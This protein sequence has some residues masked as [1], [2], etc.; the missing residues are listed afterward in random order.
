MDY[1]DYTSAL[2]GAW[3]EHPPRWA[4]SGWTY[5]TLLAFTPGERNVIHEYG[6]ELQRRALVMV[7]ASPK[8]EE[9]SRR[10]SHTSR[11]PGR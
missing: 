5:Q 2:V 11:G 10:Q 3:P 6:V 1:A 8:P 9:H 7:A 4:F